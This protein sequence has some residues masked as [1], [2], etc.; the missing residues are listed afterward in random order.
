MSFG[1]SLQAHAL[2]VPLY[3]SLFS[4]F[5]INLLK[6][7]KFVS[8]LIENF[9]AI[10]ISLDC[11]YFLT[12]QFSFPSIK[13]L[14]LVFKICLEFSLRSSVLGKLYTL[15]KNASRYRTESWVNRSRKK[16]SF[17]QSQPVIISS[18]FLRLFFLGRK[19]LRLDWSRVLYIFDVLFEIKSYIIVF[20]G[21][22]LNMKT[23]TN[24]KLI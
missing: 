3:R 10:Q 8:S 4:A 1:S 17:F 22:S 16:T 13:V 15:E 24:F 11:K 23:P 5:L 7:V 2:W 6:V 14:Q 19:T 18:Q 20:K 21:F 9:S 12:V